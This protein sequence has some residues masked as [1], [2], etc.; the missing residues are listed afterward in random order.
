M[1]IFTTAQVREID[2]YTIQHE[3]VASIDLMERAA[4]AFTSWFIKKF[5]GSYT[6]KIF[7]GPGNNGG[8]A[9]AVARLL[10]ERN[11]KIKVYLLHSSLKLSVDCEINLKRIQT[12]SPGNVLVLNE[13]ALLPELSG[14]DIII[15][16]I[17]GSGITRKVTGFPDHII[18][19]INSS[20]AYII[21]IDIPSGLFGEDNRSNDPG[22]IIR[23][24]LTLSFQ[25]PFLSFFFAE[26]EIFTGN[27]EIVNIGLHPAIIND[28]DTP[29][30]SLDKEEIKS[31]I[32]PRK[33]FSHK[34]T[35]GHA[36]LITG[37]YSMMGAAILTTKACLRGGAGLVTA[38]IPGSGYTIMQSAVPE[39]LTS[40][41]DSDKVFSGI[42]DLR[43]FDAV[44][45][46]PGLGCDE[47]TCNALKMVLESIKIPLV[48]DADALN[49]MSAHKDWIGLLP[50]NTILTPHPGEF[51]RLTGP[52]GSMYERFLKQS[53]FSKKNKVIIAL[54]GAHTIITA[55]NGNAWFNTTGNP[56]MATGGSG[57]VLTG[58][59]VAFLA[60]GYPPLDAVKT[61]VFL[62]GLAGD[63]AKDITGEE[64]L[65][66]SD[67][68]KYI[69]KAFLKVKQSE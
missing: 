50:E 51:D 48:L 68:I 7:A 56:G 65:I 63:L 32:K 33:K 1:K 21:S 34:G 38:H 27:W 4:M 9:L 61:G 22:N 55:P 66:A 39:A 60:Q 15:D 29:Y 42:S 10:L 58:L 17:F 40:I 12:I 5:D 16:G 3:P 59:I 64:S 24:D 35:Y 11:Y 18:H 37:R 6:V 43:S 62:H 31:L 69:G 67:L 44:G 25:F 45:I 57:D 8:D 52:S 13:Q 36:L 26:N 19:H 20:G 2:A 14:N 30:Q 41:D 23:A 47:K 28:S 49:I 54:K 46:G 53:D